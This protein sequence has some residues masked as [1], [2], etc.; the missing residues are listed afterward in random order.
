MFSRFGLRFF[1]MKTTGIHTQVKATI[2]QVKFY[3]VISEAFTHKSIQISSIFPLHSSQASRAIPPSK[4]CDDSCW[5]LNC[6]R[7]VEKD[8][9]A[10]E[11]VSSADE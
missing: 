4:P 1:C 5:V 8:K 2:Q 6:P 10:S 11:A 7:A 9:R 3:M